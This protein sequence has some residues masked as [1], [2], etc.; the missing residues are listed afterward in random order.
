MKHSEMIAKRMRQKRLFYLFS[1]II[2]ST[3]V[4]IL[5]CCVSIYAIIFALSDESQ[6]IEPLIFGA[7]CLILS[8]IIDVFDIRA[9]FKFKDKE[10]KGEPQMP[11]SELL[12]TPALRRADPNVNHKVL[13]ETKV[14]SYH[15]CYR[16]VKTTNELVINDFVYDQ[17]KGFFEF[18]HTLHAVVDGH[19]IK[20]GLDDLS[21]SFIVFDGELVEYKKRYI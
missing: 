21:F 4:F 15:V 11:P 17:K 12:G 10:S 18:G 13:L 20:A 16:R 14:E 3:L 1:S 19:L 7:V 5:L 8:I 2:S 6:E 9:F